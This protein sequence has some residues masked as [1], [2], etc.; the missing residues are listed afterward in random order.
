M[1]SPSTEH[2]HN[3]ALGWEK[4]NRQS[5]TRAN[6]TISFVEE[7]Q[8]WDPM[9][10]KS[11]ESDRKETLTFNLLHKHLRAIQA[12][13][14]NIE[15]T[16]NLNATNDAW[17][18]KVEE[19]N[20]FRMLLRHI[21]LNSE[22]LR[23][24]E[25][26]LETVYAYGQ[27]VLFINVVRENEETLNTIPVIQSLDDPSK[28]FFDPKAPS[29]TKHDGRYC[30]IKIEMDKKM[31]VELYP[32]LK[33]ANDL[34]DK[35]TIIDYWYKETRAAKFCKLVGGEYKREDL[36]ED[37]DV[38]ASNGDEKQGSYTVIRYIRI[39]NDRKKPLEV[40]QDWPGEGLPM[41][42]NYGLTSWTAEGSQSFPFAWHMM[43]A[44]MLHNYIGSQLAT[45]VKN[46]TS[47]KWLFTSSHVRTPRA[48][49]Y[50]KNINQLDGGMVFDDDPSGAQ[51]RRETAAPVAPGLAQLYEVSKQEIEDV[52]GAFMGSQGAE[53]KATS[54]VAL[55]KMFNRMD[56]LQ[57]NVIQAHIHTIDV[58]GSIIRKMIPRIYTENRTI[59][60]GT[61][62]GES[63]A[64]V[65]NQVL[66]TAMV[67]NNIKDIDSNFHYSIS[68]GISSDLQKQNTLSY[69]NQL[70]A[71]APQSIPLTID[72]YAKMLDTPYSEEL[73]RRFAGMVDPTLQ[74]F[75]QGQ[76]SQQQFQMYQQQQKQQQ[77]QQQQQMASQNPQAQM[78]QAKTQESV[79]NAQ[80]AQYKA[81]TE[82]YKEMQAASSTQ[83]QTQLSQSEMLSKNYNDEQTRQLEEFK[84]HMQR[85]DDLTKVYGQ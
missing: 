85:A 3:R 65:I 49:E 73:G 69:L 15:L 11:R 5:W 12:K 71:A 30:G 37:D 35:N 44:Q 76:I 20:S 10:V 52:A 60:V 31:L 46:V 57:N 40:A 39:L 58:V 24:F 34:V 59:V 68:A 27:S 9:V 18:E 47:D 23:A 75:S 50:A 84:V 55:D 6:D 83:A 41:V 51:V 79:S 54:G 32:S 70:Y 48:Q 56:I 29:P 28:A 1:K 74:K 43:D 61:P 80:T 2:I 26:S 82:R 42:Y 33:R 13:G 72:L 62:N 7:G 45:M 53:V 36:L 25:K 63:A 64:L 22:H 78:M 81:Q 67:K 38:K 17:R 4:L 16:L 8:Q 19:T 14:K 77:Q 21:M 66:S